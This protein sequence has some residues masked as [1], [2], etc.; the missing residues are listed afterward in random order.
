MSKKKS[1]IVRNA[2]LA[3][4]PQIVAVATKAYAGWSS[5]QLAN[6]RNYQMQ[7]STFPEGQFVALWEDQVV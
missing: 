3:E 7:I 1:V 4:V 6:E 2:T 5:R